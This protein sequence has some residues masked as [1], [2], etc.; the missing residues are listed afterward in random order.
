MDTQK[1]TLLNQGMKYGLILGFAQV[2]VYLL[3]YAIDKNLLV[4]F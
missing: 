2:V 3:L 1:P 4:S